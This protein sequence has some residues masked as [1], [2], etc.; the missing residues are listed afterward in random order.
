MVGGARS[1]RTPSRAGVTAVAGVCLVL[2][3]LAGCAEGVSPPPPGDDSNET[4]GTG[5][6]Q[7][8]AAVTLSVRVASLVDGS[9]VDPLNLVAGQ[10]VAL[11]VT[12][13]PA[14]ARTVRFALVGDALDASLSTIDVETKSLTGSGQVILTAP[15]EPK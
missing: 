8:M 1:A 7:G 5:G 12:S 15:T 11:V 2:A 9:P 13:K 14:V 3:S 4:G 10:A 6:T